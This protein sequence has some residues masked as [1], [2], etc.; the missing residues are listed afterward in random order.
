MESSH[1]TQTK[2]GRSWTW[3]FLRPA[4]PLRIPSVVQNF[5]CKRECQ[6]PT[7]QSNQ[8]FQSAQPNE[9][10]HNTRSH[11]FEICFTNPY[12]PSNSV[13]QP[14]LQ[15]THCHPTKAF[16]IAYMTGSSQCSLDKTHLAAVL[17]G[18]SKK[19]WTGGPL[20]SGLRQSPGHVPLTH[21]QSALAKLGAQG[22]PA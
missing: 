11:C 2:F 10:L 18:V 16:Q 4:R 21:A 17:R 3:G 12:L 9:P 8:L 1:N 6:M 20:S 22:G 14:L 19:T 7:V 13:K 5:R 15:T